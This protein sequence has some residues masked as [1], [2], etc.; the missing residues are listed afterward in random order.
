[1]A[2]NILSSSVR[3]TQDPRVGI[4]KV[5]RQHQMRALTDNDATGAL[6]FVECTA[7]IGKSP[8]ALMTQRASMRCTP[9]IES[10]RRRMASTRT[11]VTSVA[12]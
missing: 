12:P 5:G 4:E 8:A 7:F 9:E 1:M 3:G 10:P 2:N 11:P 6:W